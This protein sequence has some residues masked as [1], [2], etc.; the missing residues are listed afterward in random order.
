MAL[1]AEEIVQGLACLAS[2]LKFLLTDRGIDAELQGKIGATGLT[3]M[4]LFS[5]SGDDRKDVRA[6]F[7]EVP[8]GIDPGAEG[9]APGDKVKARVMQA[10]LIDGWEAATVRTEG[11]ARFVGEQRAGCMPLTLPGV[12]HVSL[13]RGFLARFGRC[14]VRD[15]PADGAGSPRAPTRPPRR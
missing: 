11:K 6:L 3:T 12:D 13:K 10:K 15:Y 8:F 1:A 4:S 5:L 2:D 9:L 14:G 7:T